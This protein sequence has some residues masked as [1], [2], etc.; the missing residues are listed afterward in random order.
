MSVILLFVFVHLILFSN[1]TAAKLMEQVPSH[2]RVLM[3]KDILLTRIAKLSIPDDSGSGSQNLEV[4]IDGDTLVVGNPGNKSAQ[5]FTRDVPRRLNSPW[6]RRATLVNPDMSSGLSVSFGSSVAISGDTIVVGGSYSMRYFS[7][8]STAY[9]FT[10]DIAASLSSSW[11]NI[12]RLECPSTCDPRKL[13][14]SGD[15][16]L[17]LSLSSYVR[18]YGFTRDIPG[19]PSSAWSH[20][21]QLDNIP[22]NSDADID[23]DNIVCVTTAIRGAAVVADLAIFTRDIPGDLSSAWTKRST[24]LTVENIASVS[25]AM[26]RDTIVAAY[27]SWNNNG[28]VVIFT[29]DVPGSLLS[30]WSNQSKI[31]VKD[32]V[33]GDRFG[34]D[35]TIDGDTFVVSAMRDSNVRGNSEGAAYVFSREVSGSLSS[36]WTELPKLINPDDSADKN[37]GR[38]ISISGQTVAVGATSAHYHPGGEHSVDLFAF[39]PARTYPPFPPPSSPPPLPPT[40]QYPDLC[41]ESVKLMECSSKNSSFECDNTESCQ[42]SWAELSCSALSS[43]QTETDGYYDLDR[44]LLQIAVSADEHLTCHRINDTKACVVHKDCSFNFKDGCVRDPAITFLNVGHPI[45]TAVGNGIAAA[46]CK[47]GWLNKA[48][49]EKNPNCAYYDSLP[50]VLTTFDSGQLCRVKSEYIANFVSCICPALT[51]IIPTARCLGPPPSSGPQTGSQSVNIITVI[52]VFIIGNTC[53]LAC[54]ALCY[55]SYRRYKSLYM[56]KKVNETG[57]LDTHV[58]DGSAAAASVPTVPSS[59]P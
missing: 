52:I 40:I 15:T 25:V 39:L 36:A 19:N 14:I 3:S 58:K 44:L 8:V 56:L 27:R 1:V 49:C 48:T 7:T 31:L 5:V 28:T 41:N 24:L 55:L 30:A 2:G 57:L 12:S 47:V 38:S 23:G 13:V 11:S 18:S 17:L 9:V 32:T 37:F 35:V 45:F 6:T 22:F 59:E 51:K 21:S 16:I 4:A 43:S 20:Q 46:N 33:A 54:A 10:R 29:R 53:I 26:S 50:G 42:W 34:T